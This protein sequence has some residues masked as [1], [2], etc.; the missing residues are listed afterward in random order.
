MR[1]VAVGS[2]SLA[3]SFVMGEIS[4]MYLTDLR[5]V[6]A[7]ASRIEMPLKSLFFFARSSYLSL[8]NSLIAKIEKSLLNS[9]TGL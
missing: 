4:F 6:A 5:P 1:V 8:A 2:I 3:R 7:N 9:C